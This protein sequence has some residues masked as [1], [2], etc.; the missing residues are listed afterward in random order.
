MAHVRQEFG[1]QSV[2]FEGG[3]A[4]VNELRL[5]RASL[6]YF[7]HEGLVCLCQLRRALLHAVFEFVLYSFECAQDRYPGTDRQAQQD[8]R[9]GRGQ[10]RPLFCVRESLV[11]SRF[12]LSEKLRH[13]LRVEYLLLFVRV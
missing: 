10:N 4:S 8:K 12:Y 5:N 1:L 7:Q 3:V 11:E 6:G 13:T 9:P 2:G